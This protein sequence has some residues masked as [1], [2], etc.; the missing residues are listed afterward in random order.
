MDLVGALSSALVA[1]ARPGLCTEAVVLRPLAG[2]PVPAKELWLRARASRR[3]MVS[4]LRAAVKQGLVVEA[5]GVAS[6]A[7]ALAPDVPSMCAPLVELVSRF[8]LAHPDFPITYGTADQSF[9]GGPG[10][11]W[12]PV[13]R[14]ERADGLPQS[15]LLSQALVAFGIDYEARGLGPIMWAA[16]MVRGDHAGQ[17]SGMERHGFM[18]AGGELTGPGS[19]CATPTRPRATRSSARGAIGSGRR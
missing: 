7:T 18:R 6:L 15:A 19:G 5:G 8:E 13:P 4:M 2:G 16:S 3:A 11:D 9:R 14:T 1:E 10:V 17:M 12:R